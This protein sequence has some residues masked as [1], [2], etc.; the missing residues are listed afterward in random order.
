M[1]G[2]GASFT[3]AAS[4][5]ADMAAKNPVDT[6][7]IKYL[8]HIVYGVS[9]VHALLRPACL[10]HDLCR[11][12]LSS[13]HACT[14]FLCIRLPSGLPAFKERWPD[15]VRPGSVR[16]LHSPFIAR[17]WTSPCSAQTLPV[18]WDG[19]NAQRCASR[20]LLR[21]PL[22]CQLFRAPQGLLRWELRVR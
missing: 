9:K 19:S 1:F 3:S 22:N 7:A 5:A 14:G 15:Q 6:E 11:K 18:T 21:K 20:L 2:E 16:P 8:V 10:Y 4:V 17:R 12:Y 13:R